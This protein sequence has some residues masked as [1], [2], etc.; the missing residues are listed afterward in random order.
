MDIDAAMLRAVGALNHMADTCQYL[1]QKAELRQISQE[2]LNARV[3]LET[4]I[5]AAKSAERKLSAYVGVC[6]GDKE[7]TDSI[8]PRLRAS[9][10]SIQA[11]ANG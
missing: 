7:L 1:E 2:L 10:A 5:E 6:R 11:R 3:H 8:L 4:Q 9:L